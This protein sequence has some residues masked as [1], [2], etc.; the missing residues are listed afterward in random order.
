MSD[1]KLVNSRD[2]VT[3]TKSNRLALEC[4]KLNSAEEKALA[5]EFFAGEVDDD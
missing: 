2:S 4:E 3:L 1:T 5:E